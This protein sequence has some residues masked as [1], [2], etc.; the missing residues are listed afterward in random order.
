MSNTQPVRWTQQH[1]DQ[2]ERAFP[3]LLSESDATKL[4]VSSGSRAVVHYVK[5]KFNQ[6]AHHV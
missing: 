5:A 2:L 1:I 4:L 6:Q 3:E